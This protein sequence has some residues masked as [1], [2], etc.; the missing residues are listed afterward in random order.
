MENNVPLSE[1]GN[2]GAAGACIV[3][4]ILAKLLGVWLLMSTATIRQGFEHIF[5]GERDATW[6]VAA[7]TMANDLSWVLLALGTGYAL[8]TFWFRSRTASS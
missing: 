3:F 4:G 7:G 6:R 2:Y 1:R 8:I 5:A